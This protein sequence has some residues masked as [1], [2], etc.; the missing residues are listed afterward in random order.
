MKDA[1]ATALGQAAAKARDEGRPIFAAMLNSP[2]THGG[3][4]SEVED[5]SQMI[6]AVEAEGWFLANWTA[7]SDNKGKPQ[8]YPVFRRTAP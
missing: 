1:K 3:I 4:S 6:A 8:A 7:A 5:W 2:A